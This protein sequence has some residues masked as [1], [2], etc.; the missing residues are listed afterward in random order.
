[1]ARLESMAALAVFLNLKLSMRGPLLVLFRV[2]WPF[3]QVMLA[4]VKLIRAT[5]VLDISISVMASLSMAGSFQMA[6]GTLWAMTANVCCGV[7]ALGSISFT[8][9][10]ECTLACWAPSLVLNVSMMLP[11][12]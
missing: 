10:L 6:T 2:S 12:C 5:S 7:V 3:S 11:F 8:Q 9:P 1:M 4:I